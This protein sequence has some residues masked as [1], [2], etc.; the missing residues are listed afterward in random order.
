MGGH[1][2]RQEIVRNAMPAFSS[3][4]GMWRAQPNNTCLQDHCGQRFPGQRNR[5]P[6]RPSAG[7]HA[8]FWC[9]CL[10]RHFRMCGIPEQSYERNLVGL[11]QHRC[12][13]QQCAR[14]HFRHRDMQRHY[15]RPCNCHRNGSGGRWNKRDQHCLPHMQLNLGDGF[16]GRQSFR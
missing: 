16:G 7:K 13:H 14:G 15:L 10:C 3:H 1:S 9:L 4:R 6:H 12:Q 8:A 2:P 5:Q 11:R